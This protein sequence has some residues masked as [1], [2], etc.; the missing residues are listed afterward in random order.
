MEQRRH[1]VRWSGQH[2][3]DRIA[4]S[5]VLAKMGLISA[6][7]DAQKCVLSAGKIGHGDDDEAR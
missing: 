7:E 2:L 1:G 4:N 5:V 3:G 6:T